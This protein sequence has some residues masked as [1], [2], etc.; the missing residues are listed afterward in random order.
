MTEAEWLECSDPQLM[1]EF[2]RDKANDRKLRLFACACCRHI[3]HLVTDGRSRNAVETAERYADHRAG[4]RELV[5][6]AFAA[7]D[8]VVETGTGSTMTDIGGPWELTGEQ[9]PDTTASAAFMA[10]VDNPTISGSAPSYDTTAST[11]TARYSNSS[12]N[13]ICGRRD[14][15][16]K[17]VRCIFGNPFHSLPAIKPIWFVWHDGTIPKLASSIYDERTFDRLPTLADALEAA[18]CTDPD[19]LDHCRGPGPHVRGCWVLDLILG[20]E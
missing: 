7:Y 2:L 1:L 6:A 18:G 11:L 12:T 20:K 4:Y 16:C 19:I 5:I 15:F 10:V 8:A 17:M 3:W 13:Q 9:L 14:S